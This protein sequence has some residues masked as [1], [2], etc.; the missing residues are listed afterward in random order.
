MTL[1]NNVCYEAY[2]SSEE[3][4]T[5]RRVKAGQMHLAHVAR[6]AAAELVGGY[7]RKGKH[8]IE[9]ERGRFR[10]ALRENSDNETERRDNARLHAT[11]VVMGDDHSLAE[12]FTAH[13]IEAWPAI[14]AF[15]DRVEELMRD[16]QATT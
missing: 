5:F 6:L 2:F 3:I 13:G 16:Y 8:F 15:H 12:F 4:D 9:T 7:A 11:T 14:E 10:M 1:L